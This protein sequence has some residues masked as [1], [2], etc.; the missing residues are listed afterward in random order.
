MRTTYSQG[1]ECELSIHKAMN[2]K[3]E[4]RSRSL[5]LSLIV[6][7]RLIQRLQWRQRGGANFNA[8]IFL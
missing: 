1:N 8:T 6:D 7:L 5:A 3:Y 2:A 4:G